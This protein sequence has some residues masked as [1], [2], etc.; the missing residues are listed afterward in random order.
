MGNRDVKLCRG[1]GACK[2]GIG[3]DGCKHFTCLFAMQTRTNGE[4]VSR[5]GNFQFAEKYRGHAIVI[6]LAGV[7]DDFFD[8]F[9]GDGA[10]YCGSFNKFRF[11]DPLRGFR[12]KVGKALGTLSIPWRPTYN[13]Q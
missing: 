12:L 4:V 6:M 9:R 7:D 5:L 11:P 3:F 1:K 2:G 8:G 10:G 13:Y